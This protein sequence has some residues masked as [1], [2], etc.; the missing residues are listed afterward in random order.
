[1]M[2][3]S[4]EGRSWWDA[5]LHALRPGNRTEM[6]APT[7]TS[8]SMDT[9]AM[10]PDPEDSMGEPSMDTPGMEPSMDAPSMDHDH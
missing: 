3:K 9:P 1:M 7:M 8:S 2:D 10:E 4:H 5:L 6:A